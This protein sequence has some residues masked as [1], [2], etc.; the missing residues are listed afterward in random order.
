MDAEDERGWH[1]RPRGAAPIRA[2][3]KCRFSNLPGKGFQ[4]RSLANL[5]TQPKGGGEC[6]MLETA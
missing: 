2:Y 5:S 3:S 6:R 4:R 1:N